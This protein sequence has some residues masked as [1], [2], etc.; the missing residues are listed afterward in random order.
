MDITK[1]RLCYLSKYRIGLRCQI[2]SR[3]RNFHDGGSYQE[4]LHAK[5]STSQMWQITSSLPPLET[6][7]AIVA[8]I[9]AEQALVDANRRVD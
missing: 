5:I 3:L 9:E 1:F 8:E 2:F 6:Q 4:W 7:Q